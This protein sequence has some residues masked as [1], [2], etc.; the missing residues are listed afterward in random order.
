MITRLLILANVAAFVWEVVVGKMDLLSGGYY[1]SSPISQYTLTASDVTQHHEYYRIFSCAFMHAGL[2]HIA[3]NM[4]SLGSLGFFIER[5]LG[6][7][8]MFLIY[9]VSMAGAGLGIAYFSSS[10]IPTLGAS[11][12]IFGLFGALFA[13][14]FKLG[15]SGM[16]LVRANLGILI[17]NLFIT[18][19]LPFISKQAHIAGL[20]T[21][22]VFTYLI[23]YPPKPVHTHVVDA[24]T[25]QTLESHIE[26]P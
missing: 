24:N 8:R 26:Q 11:G 7:V 21:G 25:G 2:M 15:P 1:L 17:L 10:D 3:V 23:F 18:F 9:F 14:G 16:Q 6:S 12:A 19:T 22:F 13:L 5:A 4:I 20:I